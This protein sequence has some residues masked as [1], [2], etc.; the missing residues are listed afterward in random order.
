MIPMSLVKNDSKSSITMGSSF[1]FLFFFLK[2]ANLCVQ[3][4]GHSTLKQ[5]IGRDI[6]N[7][8]FL[9]GGGG[10]G[11]NITKTLKNF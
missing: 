7:I 1:F 5:G 10:G 4:I 3:N 8:S 9:V 2:K 6:K 11:G